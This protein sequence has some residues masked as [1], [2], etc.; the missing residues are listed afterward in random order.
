MF[1][2]QNGFIYRY[3]NEIFFE[4]SEVK[5]RGYEKLFEINTD[6]SGFFLNFN[7]IEFDHN[8][9]ISSMNNAWF[10]FKPDRMNNKIYKYKINEGDIIKIG[11]ITIRIKEIRFEDN[12]NDVYA[13]QLKKTGINI[14][15][16]NFRN[17]K[18]LMKKL[19]YI[20][21]IKVFLII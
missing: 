11:R 21:E 18:I 13:N 3:K 2:N 12:K 16:N 4:E 10:I 17:D 1:I 14:I 20:I 7:K 5:E 19:I 15:N 6:N 9:N 8:E